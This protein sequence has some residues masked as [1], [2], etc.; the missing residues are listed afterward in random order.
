VDDDQRD[1]GDSWHPDTAR[2]CDPTVSRGVTPGYVR[3]EQFV[4]SIAI[5]RNEIEVDPLACWR[6]SNV[7]P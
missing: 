2:V 6:I 5:S 7:N 3:V 1:R 4:L